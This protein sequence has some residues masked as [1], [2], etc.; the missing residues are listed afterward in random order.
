MEE[1]GF[2][3]W[4]HGLPLLDDASEIEFGFSFEAANPQLSDFVLVFFDGDGKLLGRRAI[5]LPK[6]GYHYA[7]EVLAGFATP[8]GGRAPRSCWSAPTGRR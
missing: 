6:S 7:D 2:L 1:R 5:A 3:F 8:D 4:P